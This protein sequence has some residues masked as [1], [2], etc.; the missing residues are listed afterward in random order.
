MVA[1]RF[2]RERGKCQLKGLRGVLSGL[3][4]IINQVLCLQIA[5]KADMPCSHH[6]DDKGM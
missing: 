5:K 1:F 3:L 4:N 6:K 2:E